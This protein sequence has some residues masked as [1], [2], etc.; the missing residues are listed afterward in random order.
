[1]D[2]H[3]CKIFSTKTYLHLQQSLCSS[4]VCFS[5]YRWS[6]F[7][8]LPNFAIGCALRLPSDW[9]HRN[10]TLHTNLSQL[11]FLISILFFFVSFSIYKQSDWNF[12]FVF[13]C[14]FLCIFRSVVYIKCLFCTILLAVYS[15][16]ACVTVVVVSPA[17]QGTIKM[18]KI[19]A[20]RV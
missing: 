11:R 5:L 20:Q 4:H 7:K 12:V 15:R 1:M 2:S 13:V 18:V 19:C 14:N 8:H 6:I 17:E 16:A 9:W 3:M 10:G